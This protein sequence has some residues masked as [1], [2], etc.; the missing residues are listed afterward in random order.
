MGGH[1]CGKRRY[2]C[3][4]GCDYLK[5]VA[6][7]REVVTVFWEVMVVMKEGTKRELSC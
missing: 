1:G 3:I 4:E 2:G 6:K 7:L 5:G